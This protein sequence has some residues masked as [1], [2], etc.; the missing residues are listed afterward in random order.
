M[1]SFSSRTAL[2]LIDVQL[3]IDHPSWGRRNNDGAEDA[4]LR[5]L[6][7][8]RA[9]QRPVFH[10]KHVSREPASTFR[11]G[12]PGCDFKLPTAPLGGESIIVKHTP[13]AFVETDLLARLRAVGVDALVV[14]GFIT[15]NSVEA[16]QRHAGTLGLRTFVV[17]DATA[18]FDR[19]DLDGR[20]WRAEEVHALSLSNMSG[21]YATVVD[22]EAILHE[23]EPATAPDARQ[24]A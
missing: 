10:V 17:S 2:L 8:W 20:A 3:A 19:V 1:G 12:Q 14:T 5:L 11:P 4:I 24:G 7:A 21:E 16:T 6:R 9:S 22:T 23:L 18:T 15:N 13:C